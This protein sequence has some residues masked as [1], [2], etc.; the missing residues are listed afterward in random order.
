[1][2]HLRLSIRCSAGGLALL[3]AISGD[4]TATGPASPA[5]SEPTRTAPA[6]P[7]LVPA[8][9]AA[10]TGEEAIEHLKATGEYESLG[11]AITAARYAVR[12]ISLPEPCPLIPAFSPSGGEGAR[13]AAEGE[14]AAYRPETH[15]PIQTLSSSAATAANPAHG[16][17]STF[18]PEGLRLRV[19]TGA[20][21][22]G[23]T[24]TSDWRL[25]S[26]GYGADQTPVPAGELKV[27]GQ[28]AEI[29]RGGAPPSPSA[30]HTPHLTEWFVNTPG[31]LE[32]GFTLTARPQFVVPPLGDLGVEPPEGGTPN[33]DSQARMPEQPLRLVMA[34]SGDLAPVTDAAEQR[35][36]LRDAAGRAVLAYEKLKVWDATGTELPARM[37]TGE[38]RVILSVDD[39]TACYPLIV[40]PSFTQQAYIKASNTGAYDRFRDVA[41]SGD[42]VVVGAYWENSRA[43]GVN[44]NQFNEE[45]DDSGAAYVFVRISGVWRQQAYLKASNPE[46]GN[47]HDSHVNDVGIDGDWFGYSVAID[48]D[49]LV[50]GAPNEDGGSPGVNGPQHNNLK[51][52]SGAAYIFVRTGDVWTQDAYLKAS[53]PGGYSDWDGDAFGSSVAISG[54][55]VVVGAPGEASSDSGVNSDQTDNHGRGSGAAYVFERSG[56]VWTQ[57]AYLKASNNKVRFDYERRAFIGPTSLGRHHNSFGRAVAVAGGTVVVGAPGESSEARMVDNSRLTPTPHSYLYNVPDS[58]AAYVFVRSGTMWRQQSY[59]KASNAD[60]WHRF[61]YSVAVEGDTVVVGAPGEGGFSGAAYVFIRDGEAWSQQAHLKASN[62]ATGATFGTSV[63]IAG[64]TI[65]V[66]SA[67]ESSVAFASGAVYLFAREGTIWRQGGYLKSPSIGERDWFGVVGLAGDTLVVGA[68][69]EDSNA[70]GIDGDPD[71]YGAPGSGAAYVFRITDLPT[72]SPGTIIASINPDGPVHVGDNLTVTLSIDGY[73]EAN[74]IDRFHVYARFPAEKFSIVPGSLR[75]N[76]ARGID[77]NWLRRS[78]QDGVGLGA[79]PLNA[80]WSGNSII[81]L[82]GLSLIDERPTSMRG[83]SAN[84]GF[85]FSFVLHAEAEVSGN[86]TLAA[87]L[88]ISGESGPVLFNIAHPPAGVP[89]PGIPSFGSA[90]ITVL[91]AAAVIPPI[92]GRIA[93]RIDMLNEEEVAIPNARVGRTTVRVLDGPAGGHQTVTLDAPYFGEF[94]LEDLAPSSAATPARGYEVRAAMNIREGRRM[95]TFTAPI[96]GQ[97]INPRVTVPEG[98]TADLGDTFV[99]NPGYVRGA[100]FLQGPAEALLGHPSTLRYIARL[101][102]FD[103]DGDGLPDLNPDGDSRVSA[104]GKNVLASGATY[105]AAGAEALVSFEG[106]FEPATSAF[107]GDYELVLAGLNGQASYWEHLGL[108]LLLQS[109]SSD[110]PETYVREKLRIT[111]RRNP[112]YLIGGL[113]VRPTERTTVDLN[114]CLS[115]VVIEVETDFGTIWNPTVTVLNSGLNLSSPV[116]D[117]RS[118]RVSLDNATGTPTERGENS[119]GRIVLLLPEG[120]YDFRVTAQAGNSPADEMTQTFAPFRLKVGCGERL[121]VSPGMQVEIAGELGCEAGRVRVDGSVPTPSGIPVRRIEWNTPGGEPH[122][123][124]DGVVIPC[125]LNPEFSFDLPVGDPCAGT[126]F[127]VTAY[128]ADGASASVTRTFRDTVPP[129]LAVWADKTVECGSLW[130]FDPPVALDDCGGVVSVEVVNTFTTQLSPCTSTIDRTWRATDACGNAVEATQRVTVVDTTPPMII[131]ASNVEVECPGRVTLDVLVVENCRGGTTTVTPPNGS[132]FTYGSTDVLVRT[133]DACGLSAERHVT[134]TV[135]NTCAFATSMGVPTT[136]L[137]NAMAEGRSDGSLRLSALGNTL[138]DGLRLDP[139]E[140]AGLRVEF[141]RLLPANELAGGAE[142]TAIARGISGAT[143]A[144]LR[145]VRGNS[146][147]AFEVIPGFGLPGTWNY[148]VRFYNGDQL[149]HESLGRTAP[150]PNQSVRNQIYLT[151]LPKTMRVAVRPGGGVVYECSFGE[152]SNVSIFTSGNSLNINPDR[153]EIFPSGPPVEPVESLSGLDLA[154]GGISERIV[155]GMAVTKFGQEIRASQGVAMAGVQGGLAVR[156]IAGNSNAPASALPAPWPAPVWNIVNPLGY[157]GDSLPGN[158]SGYNGYWEGVNPLGHGAQWDLKIDLTDN[159]AAPLGVPAYRP[160]KSSA[161]LLMDMPALAPGAELRLVAGGVAEPNRGALTVEMGSLVFEGKAGRVELGAAFHIPTVPGSQRLEVTLAD[162]SVQ[163]FEGTPEE[164]RV[165]WDASAPPPPSCESVVRIGPEGALSLGTRPLDPAC[166]VSVRLPRGAQVQATALT[167]TAERGQTWTPGSLRGLLLVGKD[168]P[169]VSI[170]GLNTSTDNPTPASY[171]ADHRISPLGNG[172]FRTDGFGTLA[173]NG[174]TQ[175]GEDGVAIQGFRV[176]DAALPGGPWLRMNLGYLP[177]FAGNSPPAGA[178]LDLR[179]LSEG[180]AVPNAVL[181]GQSYHSAGSPLFF[182]V[183]FP[184]LGA[185]HHTLRV[186]LDNAIV[187][188]QPGRLNDLPTARGNL[189]PYALPD[190]VAVRTLDGR[191]TW[192]LSWNRVIAMEIYSQPGANP[193][194]GDRVELA[195]D[196]GAAH[197][198]DPAWTLEVRAASLGTLRLLNLG[199]RSASSVPALSFEFNA[200][201]LGLNWDEVVSGRPRLQTAPHVDG[202][203]RNFTLG[204]RVAGGWSRSLELIP[205]DGEGFTRLVTR[206]ATEGCL[207]FSA[208][209]LGDHPNPVDSAGWKFERFGPNDTPTPVNEILELDGSRGLRFDGRM[210]IE[211]PAPASGVDV[212][213]QRSGATLTFIAFDDAGEVYRKVVNPQPSG[214]GAE[215]ETIGDLPGCPLRRLRLISAGG[216][217]DLRELCLRPFPFQAVAQARSCLPLRTTALGAVPNPWMQ[218]DLTITAYTADGVTAPTGSISNYPNNVIVGYDVAHQ[219]ELRFGH[220]SPQ[221]EIEFLSGSGEI[222]FQAYDDLGAALPVYR[223]DRATSSYGETVIFTGSPRPIARVVVTSPAGKTRLMKICGGPVPESFCREV[224]DL[225]VV[226]TRNPQPVGDTVWTFYDGAHLPAASGLRSDAATGETGLDLTPETTI[227]FATDQLAADLRLVVDEGGATLSVEATAW[228]GGTVRNLPGASYAAGVHILN[229]TDYCGTCGVGPRLRHV[230]L[231]VT[232]GHALVTRVYT[233]FR[234][235]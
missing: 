51:P 104:A 233:P 201:R 222:E 77:E 87:P 181:A 14:S 58:G 163:T 84:N 89:P 153:M 40:D 211:L 193:F 188:D 115:E 82:L 48:G 127:T 3:L 52:S 172:T 214:D 103:E 223:L 136:L 20:A 97:D 93:A 57:Q 22:D 116:P 147:A 61:G 44:G 231:N 37:E 46:G 8:R 218:G 42:T 27:T 165:S 76:D 49:K 92:P 95:E 150:P 86:L 119:R 112:Q 72:T 108:Q 65:I 208:E 45:A 129:V 140:V 81:G 175:S 202:P 196:D 138:E 124:C 71:N 206:P 109:G 184:N 173:L 161:G 63:A 67:Y 146:F 229:L 16:I 232:E 158:P 32:H 113:E 19:G 121:R 228:G 74:E 221:V 80:T 234:E 219:V 99:M 209:T 130:D 148:G 186:F 195:A 194:L 235:E 29:V 70:R 13:R 15:S 149:I 167:W 217:V 227:D 107:Q 179:V 5:V 216:P 101:T 96:L 85:L 9:D 157:F 204:A 156:Y 59:L 56:G 207:D 125:G 144:A 170:T 83:T 39:S 200:G 79:L 137:G 4:S 25:E 105:S 230:R 69:G 135:K 160:G 180:N 134:V 185:T 142:F 114:Y 6:A 154:F 197:P 75:I 174:L 190:E 162:G 118:Y 203:W 132:F 17:S 122:V 34:V 198:G 226:P 224:G 102:D 168:N 36:E 73:T 98:G 187:F 100:V 7:A 205:I 78:P 90:G 178:R 189:A 213:F 28:R 53:N 215:A 23:R 68:G 30:F 171:F 110:T 2:D 151:A 199:N 62:P 10:L 18:T 60:A 54:D 21:E 66:G 24:L 117:I 133:V 12:F 50:I 152:P 141:D 55:T 120:D 106:E 192:V 41:I 225:T 43:P 212:M 38:G 33:H 111:E 169:P 155:T 64:D 31:G 123:V 143:V 182:A 1:M 183:Q 177:F 139:G 91:P 191:F 126:A 176:T 145:L 47:Q 159:A 220:P 166:P 164:L 128:T 131:T 11:A 26:L 88:L 35:L 210:D 94:A